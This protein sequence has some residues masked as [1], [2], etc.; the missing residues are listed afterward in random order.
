MKFI[1]K[2]IGIISRDCRCGLDSKKS[3]LNHSGIS[4][5][6]DLNVKKPLNQ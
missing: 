5:N 1:C 3:K 2:I 6:V 4:I